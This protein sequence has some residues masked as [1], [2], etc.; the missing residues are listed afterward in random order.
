MWRSSFLP[1][2]GP[3]SG[4][5]AASAFRI[6]PARSAPLF[7]ARQPFPGNAVPSGGFPSPSGHRRSISANKSGFY[8]VGGRESAAEIWFSKN[9]V[10]YCRRKSDPP[11][12]P[13]ER[14]DRDEPIQRSGGAEDVA[15]GAS[16]GDAPR[17]GRFAPEPPRLGPAGPRDRKSTRLNSSHWS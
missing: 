7:R 3:S 2:P 13:T 1:L 17:A 10:L 12:G 4:R 6:P 5:A 14:S 16:R 15:R 11:S 8:A 9:L